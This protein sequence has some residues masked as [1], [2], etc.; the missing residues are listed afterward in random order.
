MMM[1]LMMTMIMM[2]MIMVMTIIVIMIMETKLFRRFSYASEDSV[3]SSS[4]SLSGK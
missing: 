1:M 3:L 4:S 2:I